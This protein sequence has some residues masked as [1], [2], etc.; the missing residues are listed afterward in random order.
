MVLMKKYLQ[1]IKESEK[2]ELDD[3]HNIVLRLIG[4]IGYDDVIFTIITSDYLEDYETPSEFSKSLDSTFKIETKDNIYRIDVDEYSINFNIYTKSIM[5]HN[6]KPLGMDSQ[7]IVKLLHFYI[8][9]YSDYSFPI[10]GRMF[11]NINKSNEELTYKISNNTF[12]FIGRLKENVENELKYQQYL[13]DKGDIKKLI[14][15]KE[16][17]PEIESKMKTIKKLDDWS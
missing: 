8:I 2:H 5:N 11:N 12:Y 16:L 9:N 4:M 17:H 3:I 1:Y 14:K 10:V 6:K 7:F 15:I 13:L